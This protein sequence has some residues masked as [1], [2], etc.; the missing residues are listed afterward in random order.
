[1]NKII[2]H[3]WF[4]TQAL[5][6]ARFYVSL[7]EDSKIDGTTVIKN[8]PSGDCDF[9]NFTLAGHTF[10]A[11]SAGPNF[12]LNPSISITVVFDD[13]QKL[14]EVYDKLGDGGEELMPLQEYPFCSVYGW[15]QD[16]FGLSWQ[17][18][19]LDK[20][21]ITHTIIFSFLFSQDHNGLSE[22]ASRY[23]I[24]TFN[25]GK[26][27]MLEYYK[28]N[29]VEAHNARVKYLNFEL[30]GQNFLAMDNAFEADFDFNEGFSFMVMC[31]DQA[32]VD[33]YWERLSHIPEAEQCGWCKDRFGVSWQIVPSNWEDTLFSGTEQEQARVVEA[34]LQMKKFDLDLLEQAR[35]GG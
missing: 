35:K 6:A 2:P 33:Y 12:T 10:S 7:F 26:I 18:M 5:E 17:L 3:L 22:E 11:I 19:L 31:D 16:R 15:I 20:G 8:T 30:A 24:E 34:F 21:D 13:P 23:Y 25:E 29:E 1:M 14:R 9:V 28:S 4:D 32:E 27:N